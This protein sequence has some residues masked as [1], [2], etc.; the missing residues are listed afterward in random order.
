MTTMMGIPPQKTMSEDLTVI[1]GLLSSGENFAFS[2]FSDGEVL[3]LA[4]VEI[5]MGKD[6]NR[7]HNSVFP[8]NNSP[9][10][11]KHYIPSEHEFYRKKLKEA[12]QYNA[13]NYYKGLSC[14]CCIVPMWGRPFYDFQFNIMGDVN[15]GNLTWSNLLINSNYSRFMKETLPIFK[16]RRVAMVVNELADL[17]EL[18]FSV[19]KEFRIGSNCM[20]NNYDA[21]EEIQSYIL[22]EKAKDM[23]FLCAASSLS[24]LIIHQ[25]YS[26]HPDNT[27]IDIGSTLNPLMPGIES[28][29]D[30][31]K[32]LDDPSI[33]VKE[34]IW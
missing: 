7:I 8:A 12:M 28:R 17:S 9:D 15:K 33:Q 19:E 14:Q 6:N 29:R 3:L 10:D 13:D 18:P 16:G 34:C 31:M 22:E 26:G 27:Y 5:V 30:Y 1:N 21:I 2:R 11:C 20:V 24:N 23:V 4:K 25:C 32:Q